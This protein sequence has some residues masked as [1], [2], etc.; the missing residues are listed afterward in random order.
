MKSFYQISSRSIHLRWKRSLLIVATIALGVSLVLAVSIENSSIR[1]NLQKTFQAYVGNA[2]LIVKSV[3]SGKSYD[4]SVFNRIRKVTGVEHASSELSTFVFYKKHDVAKSARLKALDYVPFH[5]PARLRGN[6]SSFRFERFKLLKLKTGR[7]FSGRDKSSVV[8][9]S[10]LAAEL[11][12]KVGQSVTFYLQR[13]GTAR[14]KLK[15]IGILEQG[16]EENYVPFSMIEK[17]TP[18]PENQFSWRVFITVSAGEKVAAVQ[19]RLQK[20]LGSDFF[21]LKAKEHAGAEIFSPLFDVMQ[22]VLQLLSFAALGVGMFLMTNIFAMTVS[23]RIREFGILRCAGTTTGQIFRL[24]FLEALM[25]GVPGSLFGIFLGVVLSRVFL[26]VS[27]MSFGLAPASLPFQ[28]PASGVCLGFLSGIISTALAVFFPALQASR[29]S[30]METLRNRVLIKTVFEHRA[31]FMTGILFLTASFPLLYIFASRANPLSFVIPG[32]LLASFAT[33]FL[34]PHLFS[35]FARLTENVSRLFKTPGQI[36]HKNLNWNRNRTIASVTAVSMAC[37]IM[38]VMGGLESSSLKAFDDYLDKRF[39]ADAFVYTGSLPKS[40]E[41]VILTVPGI[42]DVTSLN[43]LNWT[44]HGKPAGIQFIDPKDYQKLGSLVL[45]EGEEADA[46]AKLEQ[47]RAVVITVEFSRRENVHTGDNLPIQ[48]AKGVIPFE[49]A[50]VAYG[51]FGLF[52][53]WNDMEELFDISTADGFLMK[54][55]PDADAKKIKQDVLKLLSLDESRF[56]TISQL[57]LRFRQGAAK[58]AALFKVTFFVALLVTGFSVYNTLFL[59]ILE[60]TRELGVMR[61]LGFDR[62]GIKWMVLSEGIWVCLAGCFIGSLSGLYQ[63]RGAVAA[64]QY[65]VF[66]PAPFVFPLKA[67]LLSALV[68]FL[69]SLLGGLYPAHRASKMNV[70]EALRYE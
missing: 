11:E 51:D 45:K 10:A 34:T 49:V 39:A 44:I 58:T 53:S 24:I 57:K 40:M 16:H 3:S 52:G 43:Y 46:F 2:H 31:A 32:F 7:F 9:T 42:A 68:A 5:K 50:G 22:F 4:V 38:V 26:R 41:N 60:R 63:L 66:V 14:L 62:Q 12:K 67:I 55:K 59:N 36:A 25:L 33:F 28:I 70:V 23:E 47:G 1:K 15:I 56:T 69:L 35:F 19:R 65:F 54:F 20:A 30:P 6:P 8:L 37:A 61:T 21:V 48:T 27:E 64:M 13:G 29:A 18:L 17:L